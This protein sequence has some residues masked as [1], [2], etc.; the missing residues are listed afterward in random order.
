MTVR[1]RLATFV[2]QVSIVVA[3]TYFVVGR[4]ISAEAWF[5]SLIALAIN[6]QLLEPYFA[7]P[8]DVLANSIVGLL[9]Y[10]TSSRTVAPLGWDAFA[11]ALGIG[12]GLSAVA[13]LLGANR[14]QSEQSPLVSLARAS[15][16]LSATVTSDFIYSGL[17]WLGALE[18]FGGTT[19]QFWQCALA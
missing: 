7:K 18:A 3:V 15:R 5:T 1:W 11:T 6:R 12:L 8:V 9:L 16:L 10:G 13:L 17:F 19:L 2:A 14:E 4:P